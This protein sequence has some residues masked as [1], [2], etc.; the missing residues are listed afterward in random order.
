MMFSFI[1]HAHWVCTF[2]RCCPRWRTPCFVFNPSHRRGFTQRLS[3]SPKLP[4][5]FAS[6][7]VS[8]AS[9]LYF[10]YKIN[11]KD[12]STETTTVPF[13]LN[14]KVEI[15][16]TH[17]FTSKFLQKVSYSPHFPSIW[18]SW[19]EEIS[20]NIENLCWVSEGNL[21]AMPERQTEFSSPELIYN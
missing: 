16:N 14:I 7:Y 20:S 1:S 13:Y 15:H 10:F 8:T 5:V 12:S 11:D 18:K 6:G 9:I 4:R 19:M 21:R 17:T 2:A 3:S